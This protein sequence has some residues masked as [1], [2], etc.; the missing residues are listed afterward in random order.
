MIG[1]ELQISD[2]ESDHSTNCATTTAL[3]FRLLSS[4]G[5]RQYCILFSSFSKIIFSF[6]FLLWFSAIN[7]SLP[8]KI[9]CYKK[10]NIIP[11]CT[12]T[13]VMMAQGREKMRNLKAFFVRMKPFLGLAFVNFTPLQTSSHVRIRYAI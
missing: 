10:S 6:F 12:W 3:N 8:L 2:V 5:V 4:L 1:F 7:H 13:F 11:L 9:L